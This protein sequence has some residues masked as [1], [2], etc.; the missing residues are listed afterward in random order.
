MTTEED[1]LPSAR[2]QFEYYKLLG[3]KTFAQLPEQDL[4][5]K[6][7][8]DSNSIAI[9]VQHLSGNMRSRWTDFLSSDVGQI[10]FI[11]KMLKAKNWESLSVSKGK[12]EEFNQHK[13]SRGRYDGHYTDDFK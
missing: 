3:E 1:Y 9:I 7:N 12:S 11:G 4:F 2:K 13:L 5:W 6:Y 10:V 8:P